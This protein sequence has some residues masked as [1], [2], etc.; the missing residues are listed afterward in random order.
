VIERAGH[1]A[2]DAHRVGDR[3]LALGVEL[4][5]ERLAL[6]HR[7]HIEQRAVRVAG[8]VERQDVGV[9]EFCGQ[10]DFAQEALAAHRLRHVVAQDLDGDLAIVLPV[11]CEVDGSHA[12]LAQLAV[13]AVAVLQRRGQPAYGVTHVR[14][15]EAIRAT[16]G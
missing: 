16:C 3:Q 7:H 9:T 10:L 12:A 2:R 13:E 6:H 1:L 14:R 8:V 4:L 15:C 11:V 5:T